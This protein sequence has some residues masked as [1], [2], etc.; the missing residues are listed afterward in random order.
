MPNAHTCALRQPSTSQVRW[1]CILLKYRHVP[2][3]YRNK[4]WAGNILLCTVHREQEFTIITRSCGYLCLGTAMSGRDP[5]EAQLPKYCLTTGVGCSST[6]GDPAQAI[7][8]MLCIACDWRC[9]R[10]VHFVWAI[11]GFVWQFSSMGVFGCRR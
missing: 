9:T 10:R 11:I 8:G 7:A 4:S 2:G 3:S 5:S 6:M 1:A